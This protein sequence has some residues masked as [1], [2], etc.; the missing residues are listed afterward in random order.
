MS[1]SEERGPNDAARH[2]RPPT[3]REFIIAAGM[4]PVMMGVTGGR[5]RP[6]RPA[7]HAG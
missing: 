4:A 5:S 3:R 7:W 1:N 6:R 2:G